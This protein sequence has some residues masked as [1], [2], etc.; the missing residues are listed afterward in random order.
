MFLG[1]G[2]AGFRPAAEGSSRSRHDPLL[3]LVAAVLTLRTLPAYLEENANELAELLDRQ[4]LEALVEVDMIEGA[5][6]R[7]EGAT[8]CDTGTN[9]WKSEE[10]TGAKGVDEALLATEE[11]EEET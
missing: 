11:E 4:L 3:T 1:N 7:T 9:A 2:V 6:D 8:D 10:E 5:T